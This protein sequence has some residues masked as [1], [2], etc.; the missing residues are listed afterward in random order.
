MYHPSVL[1]GL[2]DNYGRRINYLRLSITDRCNLRCRYCRPA[3]GVP[4]IPHAEILRHEEILHLARIFTELGI[5]K[6]RVTGGEPFARKGCMHLLR[7]L[8]G[9]PEVKSVHL[10]TNGVET[11]GYLSELEEL[12]IGGINLS[13]DTLDP[14]RFRSITR[15]NLLG[16]VKKTLARLLASSIPVKINAV[17]LKD[18]TDA[19]LASIAALAEKNP[20]TVRFIE[21]MPFSGEHRVSGPPKIGLAERLKNIWPEMRQNQVEGP[22]TARLFKING[23]CGR[24]GIIEGNSRKFCNTC[25]KVRITATGVLKTCLYDSGVL[26]LKWMLRTGKSDEAIKNAVLN[27]LNNR[28]AN[29]FLAEMKGQGGEQPSMATIGG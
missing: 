7:T 2:Y 1:P 22:T 12:G 3:E 17:V 29:G 8:H 6:I 9:L 15:R 16:P 14:H 25:N 26:D 19:E 11:A 10:T 4:F 13:L 24:L 21:K 5:S 20:I 23:F 18:S 27:C 28:L